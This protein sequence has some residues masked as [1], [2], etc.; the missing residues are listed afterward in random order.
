VGTV[1]NGIIN[2]GTIKAGDAVLLG[3]DANGNFITTAVKSMQRKRFELCCHMSSEANIFHRANV[4]T[5]E[6]GQCVSCGY[7]LLLFGYVDSKR[8]CTVGALKRV[9]RGNVR[10][11]MVLVPKTEV[12]PKRM[13]VSDEL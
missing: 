6:A 10:K 4:S 7:S 9:R 5:A 3:P 13:W 2:S 8:L 1:V 11:G 12:P